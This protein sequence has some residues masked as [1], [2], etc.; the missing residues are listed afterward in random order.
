ML[1]KLCRD[2]PKLWASKVEIP[3][4]LRSFGVIGTTYAAKGCFW[5]WLCNCTCLYWEF[6]SYETFLD[7]GGQHSTEVSFVLLTPAAPGSIPS[8]PVIFHH[9]IFMMSL[10]LINGTSQSVES[11]NI[12]IKPSITS[13][14]LI[15][16][17]NTFLEVSSSTFLPP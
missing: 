4:I 2:L 16:Q 1:T 6:S 15:L 13:P 11:L 3:Q 17:K 12:L 14:E 7:V 9:G 5:H 10:R 8:I